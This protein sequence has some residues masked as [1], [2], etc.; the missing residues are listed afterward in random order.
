MVLFW[1]LNCCFCK[2]GAVET[3]IFL[4]KIYSDFYLHSIPACVVPVP[5]SDIITI[6]RLG[7][8]A[9][10]KVTW[11]SSKASHLYLISFQHCQEGKHLCGRLIYA[12]CMILAPL[13]IFHEWCEHKL[14]KQWHEL[15]LR[16]TFTRM[17]ESLLSKP[18]WGWH[19]VSLT[20]AQCPAFKQ[21]GL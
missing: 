2:W 14:L 16:N 21:W 12:V 10:G 9:P 8:Y 15:R 6:G 17:P 13:V 5:S 19:L 4:Y 18:V 11:V 7:I 3:R 20:T 1:K